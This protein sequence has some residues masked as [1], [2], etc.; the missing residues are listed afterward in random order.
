MKV[1]VVSA[2]P[3]DMEIGCSGTLK[4]LKDQGA[5]VISI[6][7]VQPSVEDNANRSKNTVQ[8]ELTDSY[9][10]SKF[11]LRVFDTLLHHNGRPNLQADNITMTRLAALFEPCDIVILPNPE[12]YHQ[13]HKNTYDLAFP[14]A[15]KYSKEIWTMH[16][17]PYCYY[18][19]TNS[20]NL[21]YTINSHWDFKQSLLECYSSYL[22][23]DNISQIKTTNNYWGNQCDAHIAEA[24]TIVQKNV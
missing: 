12:D 7:T 14:L 16:S 13:D 17:W 5:Y 10:I 9:N 15:L 20:A 11:E 22:D 2:H 3:D 8:K 18:Y 4:R 24:F 21:F 23:P 1:I 6:V 19:K